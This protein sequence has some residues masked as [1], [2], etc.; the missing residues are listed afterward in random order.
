MCDG[1]MNKVIFH[2]GSSLFEAELHIVHLYE[3]LSIYARLHFL[4]KFS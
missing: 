4:C 3:H 1:I 2:S